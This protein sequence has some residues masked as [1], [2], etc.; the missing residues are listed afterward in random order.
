MRTL[1]A[2]CQ[3]AAVK[4]SS[5]SDAV[6]SAPFSSVTASHAGTPVTRTATGA[7]GASPSATV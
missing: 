5:A 1:C 6:R 7:R 3:L 2:T 4:M